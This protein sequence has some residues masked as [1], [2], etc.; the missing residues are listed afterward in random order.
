MKSEKPKH[1]PKPREFEL[2]GADELHAKL[3]EVV[4]GEHRLCTITGLDNG[5]QIEVLYHFEL[6]DR[7]LTLR[8]PLNKSVASIETITGLVPAAVLYEREIAEMLGV[9]IRNHPR[10]VKTFIAEDYQG[11]PPLRKDAPKAAAQDAPPWVKS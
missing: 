11:Q 8:V 10:P 2:V 6:P 5:E 9:E 7:L 1:A 4:K 3:G